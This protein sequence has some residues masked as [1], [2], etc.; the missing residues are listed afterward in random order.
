VNCEFALLPGEAL[1]H[2]SGPDT[3]DF[4]QGQTTCDTR[5][6]NESTTLP[7]AYCTPQGRVVCDFMLL[8]LGE[9]HAALRLRRDILEHAATTLGKYILFS[10]AE[11]D[12]LRSDWQV[13]GCWGREASQLVA[14]L[15]S[16]TPT[17]RFAAASASG[18]LFV[19]M[20]DEGEQFE[21]YLDRSIHSDIPQQLSD[22]QQ[23]GGEERW[24]ALQIAAGLGRIE[25]ATIE[26][27]IPQM[28]N[29]DATGHIS[30]NKGCYTGQEV[31][32]RLHYRGKSKRR[33]YLAHFEGKSSAGAG[34]ELYKS[35]STQSVGNLVN[36]V[37]M[38]SGQ[39]ASLV[40]TTEAGIKAG[41]H[42]GSP[43]GLAIAIEA[44]PYAIDEE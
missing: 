35:D 13:A 44:L 29:Y 21:C 11:L 5:Q 27:F 37:A 25:S 2:I 23:D 15:C 14:E 20:D 6:L 40:V 17:Q 38:E 22:I 28:L 31:V 9:D 33:M 1:L 41:L 16:S 4:L 19:Q 26:S 36:S 10:K 39:T 8:L 30:F 34:T 42:L 32:A 3:L 7:G 12:A 24:R 43:E 18:L